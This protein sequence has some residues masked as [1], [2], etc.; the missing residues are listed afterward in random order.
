[1]RRLVLNQE[2]VA[3]TL[4]GH[5]CVVDAETGELAENIQFFAWED[6]NGNNIWDGS[7]SK[8]FT[9]T[10]GPASDVLNGK[11]YFLG[12]TPGNTTRHIGL[13][14]CAGTMTVGN[15]TIACSG[16]SMNNESQSD[17]MSAN[18]AFYVEQTRNNTN[19]VCPTNPLTVKPTI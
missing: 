4:A 7:E 1:M 6:T 15:Y 12:E 17:S 14:W 5:A 13:Q 9:N 19:F 8:L 18:I 16:A 3:E 11:T 2:Q 10:Q